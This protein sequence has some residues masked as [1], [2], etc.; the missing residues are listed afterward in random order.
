[1]SDLSHNP[2]SPDPNDPSLPISQKIQHTP[3]S[4]RVPEKIS[5]GVFST[6][7]LVMDSPKEFCIDF[8]FGMARPYQVVARVIL[9]P[10]T[11]T[12][13]LHALEQNLAMYEK[14]FGAPPPD[15]K[16]LVPPPQPRPTIE[17]IYQN[18]KV[19]D[20]LMGGVYA[21]SV[22]ISHTASEFC[23]DFISGF[24]PTSCVNAR[25]IVPGATATRMTTTLKGSLAAY[26]ARLQN[27]PQPPFPSQPPFPPQPPTP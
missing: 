10:A 18:F 3:V 12:E 27:P 22:M 5:R 26:R 9:A 24:Y 20:D 19:P 4:A 17:E 11:L 6:G 23:F 21:N 2:L 16:P 14:N 1:M 7:Q 8:L 25:V 15:P 13:F